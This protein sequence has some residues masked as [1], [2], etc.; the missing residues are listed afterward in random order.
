MLTAYTLGSCAVCSERGVNGM[1]VSSSSSSRLIERDGVE[2]IDVTD[3]FERFDSFSSSLE[4]TSTCI[5]EAIASIAFFNSRCLRNQSKTTV[6]A[7]V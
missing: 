7:S 5:G 2:K 3:S 1:L 4:Q 6:E